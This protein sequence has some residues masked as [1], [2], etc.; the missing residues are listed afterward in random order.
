MKKSLFSFRAM[1]LLAV[2]FVALGAQAAGVDIPALVASNPHMAL[3]LTGFAMLGELDG[4]S[5]MK[6]LDA[7][8]SKLTAMSEKAD[9]EMKTL[10]KV[11]TD[12][13]TALENIGVEQRTLAERLTQL[14]Q[15]G[16]APGK[17]QPEDTS[18][19]AQVVK[20]AAFEA[21][22][23]GQTQKARIEVKNT[24]TGSD[25]TVAPDRRQGIVPG[26]Q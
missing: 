4:T 20:S 19:G 13:K 26:A 10:G 16:S 12:T 2:A 7:V 21:F 25:V 8:E 15:K 14:E 18:W 3:G 11:A 9:G 24:L 1:A 5:I 22:N 17:D 6:A 23:A